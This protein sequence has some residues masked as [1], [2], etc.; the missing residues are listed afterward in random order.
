VAFVF[1]GGLLFSKFRWLSYLHAAC[2]VYAIAI[3]IVGWPCPLTILEQWL[4]AA[5]SFSYRSWMRQSQV[6]DEASRFE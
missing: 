4:L 2:V 5:N 1:L 3:T 6:L